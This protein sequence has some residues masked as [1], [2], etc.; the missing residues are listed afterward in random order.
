MGKPSRW[1]RPL[2]QQWN[3]K[4]PGRLY[5]RRARAARAWEPAARARSHGRPDLPPA[6]RPASPPP[7]LYRAFLS[8][9]LRA[10]LMASMDRRHFS[11][12][13]KDKMISSSTAFSTL[14]VLV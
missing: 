14:R 3:V 8:P 9:L 10:A 1:D 6:P 11:P 7:P 5:S 13:E 12:T 2:V 4:E